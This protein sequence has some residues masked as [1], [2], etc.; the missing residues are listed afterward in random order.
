MKKSGVAFCLTLY[1]GSLLWKDQRARRE[2][3]M[4]SKLL[5][6]IPRLSDDDVALS[7]VDKALD[8]IVKWNESWNPL[9]E[10]MHAVPDYREYQSLIFQMK[11]FHDNRDTFFLKKRTISK[12]N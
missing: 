1:S 5:Y 3:R 8:E 7:M 6:G 10:W 9:Y 4:F 12:K 2:Y 11:L